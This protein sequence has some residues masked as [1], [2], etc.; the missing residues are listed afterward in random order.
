MQ[1]LNECTE[2]CTNNNIHCTIIYAH[3][4]DWFKNT[5]PNMKIPNYKDFL[6][7]IKKHK[8]ISKTKINGIPQAGIKNIKMIE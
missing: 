2:E 7:N 5:N 8:N 4:K 3:F 6:C 1:F